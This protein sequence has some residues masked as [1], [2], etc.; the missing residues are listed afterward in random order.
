M[1]RVSDAC[2]M[3]FLQEKIAVDPTKEQHLTRR[4]TM[5]RWYRMFLLFQLVDM[6]VI[7]L[8]IKKSWIHNTFNIYDWPKYF[9][10]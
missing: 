1:K 6:E 2:D 3:W 9:S 7:A 5:Q 4:C 10:R 8:D